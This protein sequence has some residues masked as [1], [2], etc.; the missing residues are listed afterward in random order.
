M[1]KIIISDASVICKIGLTPEE[2]CREQE[3]IVT[4]TIFRDN[5]PAAASQA[6]EDT[7]NYAAVCKQVRKLAATNEYV[8]LE[9]FA[10]QA[11]ALLL[12]EFRMEKL[13]LHVKK[14]CALR[15]TACPAVEIER[16]P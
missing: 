16:W 3:L 9:A 6:I 2:R 8:L 13:L 10:E 7:I 12:Q 4:I 5:R 14:P 15:H 11:A 1:D